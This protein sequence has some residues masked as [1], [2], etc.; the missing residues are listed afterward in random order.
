MNRKFASLI[1]VRAYSSSKRVSGGYIEESNLAQLGLDLYRDMHGPDA[2]PSKKYII[3][4]HDSWLCNLWGLHLGDAVH[5]HILSDDEKKR[6]SDKL[7]FTERSLTRILNH[8]TSC[9]IFQITSSAVITAAAS[10]LHAGKRRRTA[11]V[12][13]ALCNRNGE[14]SVL[15]TVRSLTVGSHKG[16]VSFPGGHLVD[17]E[18]PIEA[19]LRETYEEI[20]HSIGPIRVLGTCQSIPSS[21]G[22][23]VTP[24]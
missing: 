24:G 2:I 7:V 8:L 20:G 5:R 9:G 6:Q 4:N 23:L 17:G 21:T 14:A 18:S 16:Q 12:L 19:A 11:A 3:P 10:M 1:R 13:V 15:F 22:T